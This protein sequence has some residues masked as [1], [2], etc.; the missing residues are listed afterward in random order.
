MK[1]ILQWTI[2]IHLILGGFFTDLLAGLSYKELD[3]LKEKVEQGKE[4]LSQFEE[5]IKLFTPWI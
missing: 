3:Q 4:A 5:I 2:G 1:K